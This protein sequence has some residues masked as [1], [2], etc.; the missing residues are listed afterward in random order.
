VADCLAEMVDDRY[1]SEDEALAVARKVLREN[2]DKLFGLEL[3]RPK[4]TRR[5][6]RKR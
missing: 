5:K 1:F 3:D 4:R 6:A 2:P